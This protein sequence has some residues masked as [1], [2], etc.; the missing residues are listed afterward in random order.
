MHVPDWQV[1][2]WVQPFPSLQLAPFALA[3]FEQ[4]P[5]AGL[6]VPTS[7]HELL[8]VHTTGFEPVHVPD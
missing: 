7:W 3:G 2:V 8:A 4:V 1:S 5:V 6:Q